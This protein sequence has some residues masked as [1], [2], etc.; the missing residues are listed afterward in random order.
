[1]NLRTAVLLLAGAGAT[2]LAFQHPALGIAVLVGI[3]VIGVLN[4]L[5]GSGT[6]EQKEERETEDSSN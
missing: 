1:M 3:A 6:E 2:Y 5:L 4:L